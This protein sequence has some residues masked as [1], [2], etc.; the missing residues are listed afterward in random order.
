MGDWNQH[1][2]EAKWTSVGPKPPQ[3]QKRQRLGTPPRKPAALSVRFSGVPAEYTHETL[4]EMHV[5]FEIPGE[6]LRFSE[7]LHGG[8]PQC[9]V[10]VHYTTHEA[11]K[12]AAEE[13]N[14]QPVENFEGHIMNLT[15]KLVYKEQKG[16]DQGR[17]EGRGPKAPTAPP[18]HLALRLPP[19]PPKDGP[20]R[21]YPSVY[22][23]DVPVGYSDEN[24][25]ELHAHFGLHPQFIMGVKILPSQGISFETTSCIVRYATQK[26]ADEAVNM[27]RGQPV[28]LPNGEQKHLGARLAKPARWML[29]QGEK[30]QQ[31]MGIELEP[32][33]PGEPVVEECDEGKHCI[34]KAGSLIIEDMIS[35]RTFCEAC[36]DAWDLRTQGTG[37]LQ[38]EQTEQ[39]KAH[40]KWAAGQVKQE[41]LQEPFQQFQNWGWT[42]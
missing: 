31:G 23:S 16:R 5:S 30:S 21:I 18:P 13:L 39:Q 25:K 33:K 3:P 17:D 10:L 7:F 41:P 8:E 35:G 26:S 40:E 42:S 15:T 19:L 27:L 32:F 1:W 9:D 20:D 12:K 14:D 24:I 38:T 36:W 29:E 34:G 28:E 2:E 37:M 4:E 6:A 11:A 22:L